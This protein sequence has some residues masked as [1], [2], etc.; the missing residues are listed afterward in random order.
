VTGYG[1]RL[2][3]ERVT[4]L[5][6]HHR[7]AVYSSPRMGSKRGS[8]STRPCGFSMSRAVWEIFIQK[9]RLDQTRSAF[10]LS[11]ARVDWF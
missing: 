5:R 7:I 6:S 10:H 8:T 3:R 4:S 2:T 1:N 11:L 9:N